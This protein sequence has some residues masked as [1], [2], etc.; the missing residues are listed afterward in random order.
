MEEYSASYIF[1]HTFFLSYHNIHLIS[2]LGGEAFKFARWKSYPQPKDNKHVTYE[3][4][5]WGQTFIW[6][7]YVV[8]E[9]FSFV[10]F[11]SIL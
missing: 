1:H 11:L 8:I 10:D 2:Q 9:L 3:Q 4:P 5:F 7:S 6:G